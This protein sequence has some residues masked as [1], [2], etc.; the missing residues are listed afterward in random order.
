MFLLIC[1]LSNITCPI[2]FLFRSTTGNFGPGRTNAEVSADSV[3]TPAEHSNERDSS[4]N[5]SVPLAQLQEKKIAQAACAD[6]E[7]MEL[8]TYM[9][10]DCQI[11]YLSKR[12]SN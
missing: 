2:F 9:M 6:K 3:T 8:L 11:K 1:I 7:G 5:E 4:D 10:C 12:H